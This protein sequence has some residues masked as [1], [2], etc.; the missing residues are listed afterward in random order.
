MGPTNS[1][2]W[3]RV[4]DGAEE[5]L[6]E[7][8]YAALTSRRVAERV[9][10]R[11]QLVYYYFHTMDDLIVE[12]FRR[13]VKRDFERLTEVLASETP[14][15]DFWELRSH[16]GDARLISEFMALA[17][18]NDAVKREVIDFIERTRRIQANAVARALETRKAKTGLASLSP[19]AITFIATS[20]GLALTRESALGISSAH[21]EIEKLVGECLSVLEP[22][23]AKQTRARQR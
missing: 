10:I 19:A 21:A 5:I 15:H 9:G 18:R 2:T 12:A 7:E 23:N 8:G 4:L 1:A 14:L 13:L 20:L 6:E 22:R 17:H 16:E 3:N 11:Q